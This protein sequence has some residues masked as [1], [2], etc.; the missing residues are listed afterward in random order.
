MDAN[1]KAKLEEAGIDVEEA[2][3]R[4]MNNEGL[5][6]KFLL[7]FPQ[8]Q[9]FSKLSSAMEAEDTEAGYTAAHTLKG[10]VGN[11]SMTE[12]FPLVTQVSDALRA[13][14]LAAAREKMPELE[15]AYQKVVSAL[16]E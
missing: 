4:F 15:T 1:K 6:M 7:R 8:D 5:L 14:D 10:V 13:G 11:L 3:G 9:N 12:L 16:Q 2:L